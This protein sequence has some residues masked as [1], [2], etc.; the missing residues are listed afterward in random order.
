[1]SRP[2][3]VTLQE[4]LKLYIE[5]DEDLAI[6]TA[7]QQSISTT[8]TSF[9]S[10][11][12][13]E[14]REKA[15]HLSPHITRKD[16][17]DIRASE[18]RAEPGL[19]E[20]AHGS[21]TDSHTIDRLNNALYMPLRA[22]Q[23]S[24][25]TTGKDLSASVCRWLVTSEAGLQQAITSDPDAASPQ[26]PALF[27]DSVSSL[28]SELS[29]LEGVVVGDGRGGRYQLSPWKWGPD[30]T[31]KIMVDLYVSIRY[32]RGRGAVETT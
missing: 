8:H 1:M 6:D 19:H 15:L 14:P 3:R 23:S 16:A 13:K 31:A 27:D 4:L 22:D 18:N 2:I 26:L 32:I 9:D 12:P 25:A 10:R 30:A 20:L 17:A 11:V 5:N 29:I 24:N 21:R 28:A 7:I